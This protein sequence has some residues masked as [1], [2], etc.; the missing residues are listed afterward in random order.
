VH[1][2]VSRIRTH[3]VSHPACRPPLSTQ[4]RYHVQYLC[5]HKHQPHIL[6]ALDPIQFGTAEPD[7]RPR[8]KPCYS[9]AG[10]C[11]GVQEW[12]GSH[13]KRP[14]RQR[15][16]A[17]YRYRDLHHG[18][19]H[20]LPHAQSQTQSSKKGGVHHCAHMSG[21]TAPLGPTNAPAGCTSMSQYSRRPMHPNHS[22]HHKW[23]ES[24]QSSPVGPLNPTS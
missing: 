1:E 10:P 21:R 18:Q 22:H 12:A 7:V 2:L 9:I 20:Q 15:C 6:A 11:H 8:Y 13:Q 16:I 17:G 24:P 4:P 5:Q 19:H 3:V 23:D 14:H